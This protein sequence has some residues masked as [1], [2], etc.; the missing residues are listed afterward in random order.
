M[1]YDIVIFDIETKSS[2]AEN[3]Q[4]TLYP[5]YLFTLLVENKVFEVVLG[6]S[7]LILNESVSKRTSGGDDEDAVE[8]A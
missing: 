3:L 8:C 1:A 2:T 5:I 4:S 7:M 6:L